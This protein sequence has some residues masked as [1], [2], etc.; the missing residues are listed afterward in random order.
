MHNNVT[1]HWYQLL[2]ALLSTIDHGLIKICN[3]WKPVDL[4]TV[5]WRCLLAI[6]D[7]SDF[8]TVVEKVSKWNP[9]TICVAVFPPS[10]FSLVVFLRDAP[11]DSHDKLTSNSISFLCLL[12]LFLRG[13]SV[14]SR[15]G[16]MKT[17][18]EKRSFN[19]RRCW[20]GYGDLCEREAAWRSGRW[21]RRC[22]N[23]LTF[24]LDGGADV[25]RKFGKKWKTELRGKIKLLC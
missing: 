2:F 6:S 4:H 3:R 11:Q 22:A 18:R 19:L 7:N 16:R 10:V 17:E 13:I 14:S 21:R 15:S 23:S 1:L 25:M 9:F 24:K 5:R 20:Q 12:L 8:Q